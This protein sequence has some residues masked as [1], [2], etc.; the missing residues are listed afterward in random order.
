MG[1]DFGDIFNLLKRCKVS[2]WLRQPG[3][4]EWLLRNWVFYVYAAPY[5]AL[6]N[7]S[8]TLVSL[9]ITIQIAL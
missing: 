7:R 8:I 9:C 3:V 5:S 2:S 6:W 4:L 1:F